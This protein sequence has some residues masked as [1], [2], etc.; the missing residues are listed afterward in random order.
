MSIFSSVPIVVPESTKVVS[1][2]IIID[3][4]SAIHFCITVMLQLSTSITDFGSAIMTVLQDNTAEQQQKNK[5][6]LNM[7][8]IRVP[9]LRPK[10]SKKDDEYENQS[11]VQAYQ[12]C[13]EQISANRELI[14]LELSSAQQRA[15]ANQ[16]TVNSNTTESMELLQ[17]AE[18]LLSAL[19]EMTIKANLTTSH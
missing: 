7:P 8:L 19:E 6:L 14:Q 15:Q 3:K 12:A 5:E 18:A 1:R 2:E 16:K 4:R 11:Q 13:N 17:A 10:D 9:D